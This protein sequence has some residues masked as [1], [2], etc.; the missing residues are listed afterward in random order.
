MSLTKQSLTEFLI[1]ELKAMGVELVDLELSSSRKPLLR[2][3]VDKLGETKPQCTLMVADC[4]NVSRTIQRLIDVEGIIPGD[5]TLEVST[6]GLDRPLFNVSDYSRFKGLL[7]S[8]VICEP[9]GGAF[10]G[11]IVDVVGKNVVFEV[12]G[13]KKEVSVSDIKRAKLKFER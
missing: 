2:L 13:K 1:P 10:E 12:A 4:E 11:R 8:V 5:Y 6:P 3:Y 7:A 9:T